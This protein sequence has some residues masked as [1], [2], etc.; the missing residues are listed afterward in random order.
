MLAMD[1]AAT[2]LAQWPVGEGPRQGLGLVL[3]GQ[4][5]RVVGSLESVQWIQKLSCGGEAVD[6]QKL[7]YERMDEPSETPLPSNSRT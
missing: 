1:Q 4:P 6:P 3:G 7:F 2:R 5:S